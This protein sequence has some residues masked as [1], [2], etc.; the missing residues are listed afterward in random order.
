VDVPLL[1]TA[2]AADST[3]TV[4]RD[5]SS[6]LMRPPSA[7]DIGPAVPGPTELVPHHEPAIIPTFDIALK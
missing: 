2:G 7:S 1:T 4:P 5:D 3:I 6:V